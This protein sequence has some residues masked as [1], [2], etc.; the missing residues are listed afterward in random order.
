MVGCRD[1]RAAGGASRGCWVQ[2]SP[3]GVPAAR[4]EERLAFGTRWPAAGRD[5]FPDV[6]HGTARSPDGALRLVFGRVAAGNRWPT[7][8]V[9][10]TG[11]YRGPW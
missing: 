5:D 1:E 3:C 9:Q 2:K 8:D 4:H 7:G 11:V 6:T 10:Q